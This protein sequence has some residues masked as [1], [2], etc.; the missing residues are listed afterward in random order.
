MIRKDDTGVYKSTLL[1]SPGISHGF[2]TRNLG[3]MRKE[4]NV[5]DFC[6]KVVLNWPQPLRVSQVHGNQI[7]LGRDAIQLSGDLNQ[8][9]GIVWQQS[10]TGSHQQCFGVIVADCVPLLFTDPQSRIIG[11][12]H[13]GWQGIT[14]GIVGNAIAAMKQ[15]GA[16]PQ[17]MR[18]AIGPHIG[19]CC[20]TVSA[21]RKAMFA[22]LYGN[23]TAVASFWQDQWHLD[24]GECV[25]RDLIASGILMT[26]IDNT[27]F[28]TSC[29]RQEFFSYR[30]DSH[31]TFGET[32]AIIGF[33]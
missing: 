32:M 18:V 14:T 30:K 1:T 28:C 11:V 17:H 13:A 25:R 4:G 24:L 5:S 21:E 23:D 9:D 3:D 22:K 33:N 2:S 10:A 7:V 27:I 20:Y 29:Q 8:S 19:M 12:V 6:A 31:D 26:N 15:L 16:N